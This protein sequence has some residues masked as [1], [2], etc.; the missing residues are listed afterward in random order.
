MALAGCG[1][2]ETSTSEAGTETELTL[3]L[4]AD[5]RGGADPKEVT[6][7]C[8]GGD[9]AACAAIDALPADATEPTPA[10]QPCTQVYGGPDTLSVEGT[11][12]G[13]DVSAVFDRTDGCQIQRFDRFTD[14]LAALYPNP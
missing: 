6:L 14:V 4:D 9:E 1:E 8:P 2:G 11:L 10:D 7:T 5:G 3:R 12:R 13:E